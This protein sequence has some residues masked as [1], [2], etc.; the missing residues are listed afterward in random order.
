MRTFTGRFYLWLLVP[1]AFGLFICVPGCGSRSAPWGLEQH[2][3]GDSASGL[4]FTVLQWKE[5]KEGPMLL[6]VDDVKGSH[7]SEAGGYTANGT[8]GGHQGA[9]P[10]YTWKFETK[11][12]KA[13]T[14]RID[15]KEHDLSKGVLFLIKTKGEQVEVHQMK[16]KLSAWDDAVYRE[17]LTKDVEIP[18]VFGKVFGKGDLPK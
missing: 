5:G 7:D 12:G 13:A 16:L 3:G 14:F 1:A 11:D 2:G 9:H 15:G 17:Y 6:L 18:K 8:A 4:Q 10:G